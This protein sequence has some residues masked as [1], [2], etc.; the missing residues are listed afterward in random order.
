MKN[1]FSD[2]IHASIQKTTKGVGARG[3]ALSQPGKQ[4][5]RRPILYRVGLS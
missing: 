5:A 3:R 1:D 4:E 2:C